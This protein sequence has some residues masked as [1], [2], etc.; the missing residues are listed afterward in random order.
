MILLLWSV[1]LCLLC[2]IL[3]SQIVKGILYKN[4]SPDFLFQIFPFQEIHGQAEYILAFLLDPFLHNSGKTWLHGSYF[5]GF[6][7]Q[8]LFL[9]SLNI[10]LIDSEQSLGLSP[11]L[12]NVEKSLSNLFSVNSIDNWVEDVWNEEVKVGQKDMD[13]GRDMMAKAVSERGNSNGD[14]EDKDSTNMRTACS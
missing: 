11:W 14:I 5:I 12:K 6:P 13:M 9:P 10:C 3:W 1:C 7:G 4:S 8:S 2:L